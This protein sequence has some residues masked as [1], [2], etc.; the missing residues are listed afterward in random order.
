MVTGLSLGD[1]GR[2]RW[3]TG[4][5]RAGKRLSLSPRSGPEQCGG[6]PVTSFLKRILG[7]ERT[8]M[9]RVGDSL[10]FSVVLVVFPSRTGELQRTSQCN[11]G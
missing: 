6:N 2:C 11:L 9:N 5:A 3:G 4:E 7:K 8:E 10:G 1:V